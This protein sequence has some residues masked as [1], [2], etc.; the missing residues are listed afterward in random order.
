[1]KSRANRAWSGWLGS[2]GVVDLEHFVAVF[3]P[4]RE[5]DRTGGVLLHPDRQGPQATGGEEGVVAGDV[6]P[7]QLSRRE[8]RRPGG[9]GRRDGADQH[10][11]MADEHLGAGMD[12]DIGAERQRAVIERRRP[13]VVDDHLDAVRPGCR[14]NRRQVLHFESERTWAFDPDRPRPLA[15]KVGDAG[16]NARIVVADGHPHAGQELVAKGP[17][18]LV[19]RIGDEDLVAGLDGAEHRHSDRRQPRRDQRRIE[20]ALQFGHQRFDAGGGRIAGAAVEVRLA[21]RVVVGER[22]EQHGRAAEHRR[23]DEAELA[24]GVAAAMG[25]QGLDG[26]GG[27]LVAVS[28]VHAL[29]S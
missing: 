8:H 26:G 11:G 19:D 12:D 3:Q 5:G 7:E 15:D 20:G 9:F 18:G 24:V 23:I 17:P 29:W 4:L 25:Q 21:R 10:I 1:M 27:R 22:L 14:N 6:E 16:A 28:V 13:A 2:A